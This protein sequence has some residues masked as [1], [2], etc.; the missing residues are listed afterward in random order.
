MLVNPKSTIAKEKYSAALKAVDEINK[1]QLLGYS[2]NETLDPK[3]TQEDIEGGLAKKKLNP[4][5]NLSLQSEGSGIF[6]SIVP[7]GESKERLALE[8]A[9]RDALNKIFPHGVGIGFRASGDKVQ[10]LPENELPNCKIVVTNQE[11]TTLGIKINMQITGPAGS[12]MVGPPKNSPETECVGQ[13]D[14]IKAK[15]QT[16][17]RLRALNDAYVQGIRHVIK[18]KM[19]MNPKYKNKKLYGRIFLSRIDQESLTPTGYM[20]KIRIIVWID[21]SSES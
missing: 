7:P 1:Q 12:V 11:K 17:V 15:T 20:M 14:N 4:E 3:V 2:H 5:E 21:P 9:K 18:E 19:D 10:I 6:P 13:T 8:F 16:E